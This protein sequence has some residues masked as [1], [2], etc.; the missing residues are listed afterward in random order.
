MMGVINGLLTLLLI[1]LFL[2]ICAW[3]WSKR[4]KD[5]FD[6]MARLPLDDNDHT[7]EHSEN[8]VNRND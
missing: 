7:I 1:I 8:E 5:T 2:G 4:N 6:R 3:A